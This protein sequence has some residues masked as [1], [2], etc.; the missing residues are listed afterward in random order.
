MGPGKDTHGTSVP[1]REG[2][3]WPTTSSTRRPPT[4]DNKTHT[5]LETNLLSATCVIIH[6]ESYMVAEPV[7]ETG[8]LL[9][10]TVELRERTRRQQGRR[11][12]VPDHQGDRAEK[13][14]PATRRPNTSSGTRPSTSRFRRISTLR[15][16]WM[17]LLRCSDSFFRFKQCTE[18]V[19]EGSPI[20]E[21][22]MDL[23]YR[24]R[25]FICR[26]SWT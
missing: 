26:R 23:T 16:L 5:T 25:A 17:C 10:G 12:D 21:F 3:G 22:G 15:K 6:L 11:G 7:P 19:G 9:R 18:R 14:N 20:S 2:R 13:R 24:E 1:D 8:D 4:N